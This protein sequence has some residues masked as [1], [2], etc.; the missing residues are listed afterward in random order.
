[1]AKLS[2]PLSLLVTEDLKKRVV[3]MAKNKDRS[4]NWLCIQYIEEGLKRDGLPKSK[5]E[6]EK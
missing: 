3:K 2:E 1:M 4:Y 5:S 6:D